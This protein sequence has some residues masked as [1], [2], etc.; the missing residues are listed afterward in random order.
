MTD[1]G[2]VDMANDADMTWRRIVAEW[3]RSHDSRI[4]ALEKDKVVDEP[5]PAEILA[6]A[7]EVCAPAFASAPTPPPAEA[8]ETAEAPSDACK[9]YLGLKNDAMPLWVHSTAIGYLVLD[10][11][12]LQREHAALLSALRSDITP[13]PEF[14]EWIAARL[15]NEHGENPNVDY[16]QSLRERAARFRRLLHPKEPT[17]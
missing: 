1:K 2:Y 13:L 9:R 5:N 8:S 12:A 16:V 15:V 3:L 14:L 6:K 7:R 11:E 17:P 4:S 10:H